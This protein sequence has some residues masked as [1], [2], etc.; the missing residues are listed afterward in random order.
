MKIR[1]QLDLMAEIIGGKAWGV[2]KLKPRIYMN[3]GRKDVTAFYEFPDASYTDGDQEAD[4]IHV[5]GG[6]NFKL[7]L[8]D[9]GQAANWYRSQKEKLLANFQL[10]GLAMCV[11]QYG[12]N[13]EAVAAARKIMEQDEDFSDEQLNSA[14]HEF[15]NGRIAAGLAA[16]S[17]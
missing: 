1:E 17:L 8:D 3:A 10:A 14:S 13:D 6:S 11:M 16:L 4:A 5:L 9:C 12:L 7:F 15:L 2:E